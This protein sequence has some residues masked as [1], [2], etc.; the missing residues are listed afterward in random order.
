MSRTLKRIKLF[1]YQNQTITTHF[2]ALIPRLVKCKSTLK[3]FMCRQ[4]LRSHVNANEYRK[5]LTLDH[6]FIHPNDRL[7]INEGET[8]PGDGNP[9]LV[10]GISGF[11]KCLIVWQAQRPDLIFTNY[12]SASI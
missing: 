2:D 4:A 8:I 11:E 12:L 3:V 6:E 1:D 5:Y 7:S 9:K 10:L